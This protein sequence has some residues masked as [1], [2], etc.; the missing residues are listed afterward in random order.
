[1]NNTFEIKNLP[2]EI[3]DNEDLSFDYL[4]KCVGFTQHVP[5]I[6]TVYKTIGNKMVIDT[7]EDIAAY[8]EN[9]LPIKLIEL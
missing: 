7:T 6:F 3:R 9:N 5:F 2:I 4:S 8:I 1:M